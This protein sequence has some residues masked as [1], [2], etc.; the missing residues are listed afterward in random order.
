MIGLVGYYGYGNYGDE[1][2]LRVWRETLGFN[3]TVYVH[4]YD[5]LSLVDKIVV[6][7]GDLICINHINNNYFLCENIVKD[8]K[9]YYY[10]LGVSSPNRLIENEKIKQRYI[11]YFSKAEYISVRDVESFK[12]V[13]D[14]LGI[15]KLK[16][17][18]DIAWNFSSSVKIPKKNNV[19]GLTIRKTPVAN[20][21][22]WV[23]LCVKLIDKGYEISLLPLQNSYHNTRQLH[24]ILMQEVVRS[25]S[26]AS[27]SI[28]PENFDIEHL[29][30]WIGSLN[31]YIT[32]AF[33]GV[34]TAFKEFVPTL[35]LSRGNKLIQLAKKL[36]LERA[37]C[38]DISQI[39]DGLDFLFSK[40]YVID[41]N[42]IQSIKNKAYQDLS[43]FINEILL[44]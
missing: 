21:D 10:G 13:K 41:K 4:P 3:T 11:D 44:R 17:V 22:D 34:I 25:I 1:I 8:K 27:I 36:K 30:S 18:E 38:T 23:K 31:Y 26:N 24:L 2:F 33:H 20:L 42:I 35:I 14:Y 6:G 15:Q 7:G 19:V 9:V 43:R 40:E 32:T 28:I 12:W 37:L 5:D 16:L 29:Y 39:D